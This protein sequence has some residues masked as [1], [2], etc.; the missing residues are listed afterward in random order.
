MISDPF[1]IVPDIPEQMIQEQVAEV[2][3]HNP[4]AAV[5][6]P[7]SNRLPNRSLPVTPLTPHDEVALENRGQEK[8]S[9][10]CKQ[11]TESS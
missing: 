7:S 9:R 3:Q 2:L 4:Y 5:P 11:S 6:R 8:P 1:T 10:C